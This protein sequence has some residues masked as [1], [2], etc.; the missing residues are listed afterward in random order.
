[1]PAVL[2]VCTGNRYRS[3][4]AAAAFRY[5]VANTTSAS[6][7]KIDS[8]GT[9]T[10]PGL[11]PVPTAIAAA[12]ALGLDITHHISCLLVKE[13]LGNYN[14]V[15][16]M[17]A[18]HKEAIVCQSPTKSDRVFLLSEVVTGLPYDIPDPMRPDAEESDK[19][20]SE[21]WDLIQRGFR[22]ICQLAENNLVKG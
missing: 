4:I 11:P 22:N 7:W 9:W 17:E 6:L 12:E 2:F 13:D 16:V 14:L 18:G 1:M 5:M 8:A 15:L 20:A 10:I 19:I 3:P 21:I